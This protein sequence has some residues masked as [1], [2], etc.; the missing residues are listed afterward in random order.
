MFVAGDNKVRDHDHVIGKYRC[1]ASWS[2]NIN[3]KLTEKVPVIFDNLRG[4]D[5]HLI[6]QEIGKFDVKRS[7]IP[8]GLKKYMAFTINNNNHFFVKSDNSDHIIFHIN[9][10]PPQEYQFLIMLF[11]WLALYKG[12]VL[13]K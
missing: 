5:S 1:S 12:I 11:T 9:Y 13:D 3:L 4:Y 10:D 2:C 6:I 7:F 8:N